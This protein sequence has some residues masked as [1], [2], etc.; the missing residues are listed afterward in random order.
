M[1]SNSKFSTN[2]RYLRKQAGITQTKL[3]E[4]LNWNRNNISSYEMGLTEPNFERL[5]QIC[6][7]FNVNIETMLEIDLEND[8]T[9]NETPNNNLLVKNT[10]NF[11]QKIVEGKEMLENL[12]F[13][14]TKKNQ[15][16]ISENPDVIAVRKHKIEILNTVIN[17]HSEYLTFFS[18]SLEQ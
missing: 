6:K 11:K 8:S 10:V 3:A 4:I 1:A 9:I 7:Y 5:I 16:H 2:I 15:I 13:F 12:S 14:I 17:L 18:D